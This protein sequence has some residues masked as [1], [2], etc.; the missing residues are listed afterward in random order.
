MVQENF[1]KSTPEKAK[2]FPFNRA[3]YGFFV[4]VGVCLF[5]FSKDWMMAVS[6]FGIALVFDPF[7]PKTKWQDRQLYQR[8]WLFVHVSAVIILFGFGIFFKS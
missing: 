4:M 5:L 2:S 7:D 6:N 1:Q 3:A 8:I